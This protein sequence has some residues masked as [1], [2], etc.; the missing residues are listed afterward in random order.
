MGNTQ[1]N[2]MRQTLIEPTKMPMGNQSPEDLRLQIHPPSNELRFIEYQ[3]FNE[4]M[5]MQYESQQEIGDEDD[6]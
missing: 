4:D 2:L 5:N 1:E 3:E 6:A